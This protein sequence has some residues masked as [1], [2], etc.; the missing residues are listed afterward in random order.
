[1]NPVE[2]TRLIGCLTDLMET[3]YGMLSAEALRV[4]G[5]VGHDTGI[6]GR[7]RLIRLTEGLV[8][9]SER[10]AA[11][12]GPEAARRGEPLMCLV[13][14][15]AGGMPNAVCTW[16]A[17]GGRRFVTTTFMIPGLVAMNARYSAFE[18]EVRSVEL[19]GPPLGW[20]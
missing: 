17:S 5:S 4:H 7:R 16:R 19:D 14:A 15:G 1:M 18:G 20:I 10:L 3:P 9:D 11:A 8:S 2:W 6:Q 12:L 13:P